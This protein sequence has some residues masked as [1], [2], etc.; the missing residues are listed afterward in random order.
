MDFPDVIVALIF[1][2][3]TL[4]MVFAVENWAFEAFGIDA[5]L[6]RGVTF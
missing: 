5:V 6:G 4:L 2:G 3:K 1:A